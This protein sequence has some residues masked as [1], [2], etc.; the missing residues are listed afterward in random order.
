MGVWRCCGE[1]EECADEE[2]GGDAW[3]AGFR[4]GHAGLARADEVGD[5]GSRGELWDAAGV[6]ERPVEADGAAQVV[7]AEVGVADVERVEEAVGDVGVE[8]EAVADV[9]RFA[10]EAVAREVERDGALGLAE[11][12]EDV[13][14]EWKLQ[15]AL[16]RRRKKSRASR[17]IRTDRGARFSRGSSIASRKVCAACRGENYVWKRP[18]VIPNL[19][20][21]VFGKV[22][23]VMRMK[24]GFCALAA[25]VVLGA[26]NSDG[27]S[28]E[29]A[30]TEVTKV[31]E[32]AR[33]GHTLVQYVARQPE[34]RDRASR[35]YVHQRINVGIPEGVGNA[36]PV[37]FALGGEQPPI[38]EAFVG[39]VQGLIRIPMIVVDAEHRGYGNSLSDNPDQTTPHYV[40]RREAAEDAHEVASALR[41]IYTGPW[42]VL[43]SSYTGGLVL[44]YAAK[45]P[46]DVAAVISSAG[47]VDRPV[48]NPTYDPF[49]RELLGEESYAQVV[50]HIENLQ[51]AELFDQNWIDREFV[52]TIVGALTQY[53]SYQSLVPVLKD[54][55]ATRTTEQLIDEARELDQAFANGEAAAWAQNRALTVLSREDALRDYPWERYYLWQQ[56]TDIGEFRTSGPDGVWQRTE[57]DWAEECQA[58]FG[59]DLVR[60]H[61]GHR[62]DVAALEAAGTP[63][64]FLSGGKDPWS[65]LGLEVPPESDRIDQQ[66]RWS[67]Y[68]TSYGRHFHAPAGFHAPSG[69]DPELAR[70]ATL[71]AFELAAVEVPE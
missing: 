65:P 24:T 57:T 6:A 28:L 14:V 9:E 69:S 48:A 16:G 2:V 45:Y 36:A 27:G 15:R 58:L 68:E 5:V 64:V 35:G 41:E 42:F 38:D 23:F 53:E 49:T 56:C 33:E 25:L 31:N 13:A 8:V 63:L 12:G 62:D 4:F 26:C 40:S 20:L 19:P 52:E 71:A 3:T 21:M 61:E 59:V 32:E 18:V 7:H 1:G 50:G 22:R 60:Q 47:I 70:A 30:P 10:R 55:V 44:Q 17:Q 43:G 54:L 46:D 37:L 39:D 29:V 51:P 67:E 11:L 66:E 34:F